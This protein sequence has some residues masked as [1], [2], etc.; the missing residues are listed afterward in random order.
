MLKPVD[1][2][3]LARTVDALAARHGSASNSS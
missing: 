2:F 3:E 1:P